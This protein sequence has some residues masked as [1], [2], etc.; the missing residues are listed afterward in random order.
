MHY[1]LLLLLLL[2]IPGQG[3]EPLRVAV[4]ANFRATLEQ[5]NAAF[6]QQSGYPVV[7]SSA[8]TGVLYSQILH[9]A[10]FD[11]FFA[12]DK[13]TAARLAPAAGGPAAGAAFCY[14]T[15]SLVLAGG[16]GS[17]GQLDDPGKSLAIA[18]P[19]TA[20][21]GAAAMEVLGRAEFSRGQ[22]RKLVRGTNV[23][24][25]YQFWHSGA[26]DLALIP[27]ALA[28]TATPV[29]DA[30]HQPLEQFAIALAAPANHPA[31]ASYLKWIGS[32]RVRALITE[33]GYEPCP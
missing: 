31:L 30:W 11:I 25:A 1:F 15:G 8:S 29:P 9:G 10:P 2:P 4:A 20:P 19:A 17:L 16:D 14:A 23:V 6:Q 7:L 21:Y 26:T 28:P 27:R 12:A 24:Q 18:N 33:A 22:G 32:A 5:V 3:A 13:N